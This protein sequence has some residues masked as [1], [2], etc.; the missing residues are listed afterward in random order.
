MA[1]VKKEMSRRRFVGA[2]GALGIGGA[3]FGLYQSTGSGRLFSSG[4]AVESDNQDGASHASENSS[5]ED[6]NDEDVVDFEEMDREH[7]AGVLSFPAETEGTG[8]LPL[9][10]EMDGD[11]KVFEIT[12]EKGE[13][14]VEPGR[15]EEAWTYNG[16]VPGPEIRVTEGDT[17][18]INVY[19]DMDESTAIHWHGMK[20]PNSQDGVPFITQPPIKPGETFTYEFDAKT[21]GTHMYHSHYNASEQSSRGQ[22]GAF[23]I[24]PKDPES[25][26]A[27]DKEYTILLNDGKLGYTINGKGFPAT[28][29]LTAKLGERVLIRYINV[30]SMHHPMH[31]H[32][33]AQEV[34]AKDGYL[35]PQPYKCDN[36]DIAPGDR[37]EVIVEADAPGTWAFHCHVLPHAEGSH[38]MFGMVTVMIVED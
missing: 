23:I 26:P 34:I 6:E 24:E 2:V 25:R 13:W 16:M 11:V 36:V 27:F 33:M 30:G 5:D 9:E 14:E 18:R 7:E 29:P 22:V 28:S 37:C 1:T 15:V 32:G 4:E 17:V 8:G 20:L 19:N 38:G 12:C 10:Y 21:V 3:G 31:L 35:L